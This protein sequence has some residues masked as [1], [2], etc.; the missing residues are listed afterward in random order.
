M[1]E[2]IVE[3]GECVTCVWVVVVLGDL[4]GSGL[5]QFLGGYCGV[6]YMCAVSLDCLCCW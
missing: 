6:L 5:A 2:R 1:G 4:L 3:E